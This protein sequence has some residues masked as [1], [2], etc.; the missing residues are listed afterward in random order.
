[1]STSFCYPRSQSVRR[2]KVVSILISD[3]FTRKAI[4]TLMNYQLNQAKDITCKT[5]HRLKFYLFQL[6]SVIA[7]NVV[8][9]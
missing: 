6:K 9:S 4:M 8:L 2:C 3:F 5:F 7:V 1:M